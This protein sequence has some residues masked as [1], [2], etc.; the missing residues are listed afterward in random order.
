M[1]ICF[2]PHEKNI[3]NLSQKTTESS[4]LNLKLNSLKH[5]IVRSKVTRS[6]VSTIVK[7]VVNIFYNSMQFIELFGIF[8][9]SE[10]GLLNKLKPVVHNRYC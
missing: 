8:G 3:I 10:R 5:R 9:L 1:A 4:T 2:L 6:F 7:S